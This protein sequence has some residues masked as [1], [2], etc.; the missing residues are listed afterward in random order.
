MATVPKPSLSQLLGDVSVLRPQLAARRADLQAE[1]LEKGRRHYYAIDTNIIYFMGQPITRTLAQS[2]I[3]AESG[4]DFADSRRTVPHIGSVFRT[5]PLHYHLTVGASLA[6]FIGFSL[7]G[8]SPLFLPTA[9]WSEAETMLT[10]FASLDDPDTLAVADALF[11]NMMSRTVQTLFEHLQPTGVDLEGVNGPLRTL[12]RHKV[13]RQEGFSRLQR[14]FRHGKIDELGSRPVRTLGPK[15]RQLSD[16][17]AEHRDLE[18]QLVSDWED[19]LEAEGKSNTGLRDSDAKALA[20]IQLRNMF[21]HQENSNERMLYITLD[22]HVLLAAEQVRVDYLD[23]SFAD[24]FIRHP[25]A[26]LNDIGLGVGRPPSLAKP[27]SS[28]EPASILDWLDVLLAQVSDNTTAE[29]KGGDAEAARLIEK[30]WSQLSDIQESQLFLALGLEHVEKLFKEHAATGDLEQTI[31]KLQTAVVDSEANAWR[32]CFNVAIELALRRNPRDRPKPTRTSPPI[33]FEAWPEAAGAIEQFKLW[34]FEGVPNRG[35]Y[36]KESR[37]LERAEDHTR[38]AYYL[39]SAAFFAARG[40]WEPAAGLSAFARTTAYRRDPETRG[41]A[42]GREAN[43]FEAVARR[44]LARHRADLS[45]ASELLDECRRIYSEEKVDWPYPCDIVPERF[46]LEE[47]DLAQ[48]DFLFQWDTGLAQPAAEQQAFDLLDAYEGVLSS[49]SPRVDV[50]VASELPDPPLGS[51][52]YVL[53]QTE[54]RT[55]VSMLSVIGLDVFARDRLPVAQIE[56]LLARFE[57]LRAVGTNGRLPRRNLAL[58]QD[59][60]FVAD[61][62]VAVSSALLAEATRRRQD[63]NQ[64]H[65]MRA[66]LRRTALLPHLVYPFDSKRFNAMRAVVQRAIRG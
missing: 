52:E 51:E 42:H 5:D 65:H 40:D 53:I 48:I 55:I 63:H 17:Q 22:S 18:K 4:F 35:A 30:S 23:C 50:L 20:Q 66:E 49:L 46:S 12:V 9:L 47:I 7:T 31:E 41:G 19:A 11:E 26:F 29:P 3:R 1:R 34:G 25:A 45:R 60:S 38:Y 57:W 15:P 64:L 27:N 36:D 8:T 6:Q 54:I 43:F 58:T 32:Q 2:K 33:C 56:Q 59:N 28:D 61:L 62:A 37:R 13:G 16:W 44:H 10:H 39:A 21:A 24:A 14:L